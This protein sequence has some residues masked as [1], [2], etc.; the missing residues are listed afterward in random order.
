M[1]GMTGLPLTRSAI[2]PQTQ[3]SWQPRLAGGQKLP[4]WEEYRAVAADICQPC[5]QAKQM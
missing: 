1:S 4:G 2:L 5:P 3:D